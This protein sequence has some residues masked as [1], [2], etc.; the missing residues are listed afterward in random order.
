MYLTLGTVFNTE[1]GDLFVRVL[2]GLRTLPVRILA[3]VGRNIDP[4]SIPVVADNIRIERY[5]P[6]S[7]VLPH[8][9]LVVNHAG[10]GSVI[11]AL[12]HGIPVI[13]LPMGADQ[14]LNAQRLTVLDA[15]V[16]LDP[17]AVS[18]DELREAA[19]AVLTS[20]PLLAGARRLRDEIAEMPSLAS[21][22]TDLEDL[23][24]I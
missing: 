3:T 8:C 21:I 9:D 14:E 20:E 6:Q 17:I 16:T 11:G 22:I 23:M 12:A 15:G 4:A 5:I 10:S 24:R 13:A 2:E 19:R 7:A 18:P 1:S